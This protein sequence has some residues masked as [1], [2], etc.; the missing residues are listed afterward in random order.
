M[1]HQRLIY[2]ETA[3]EPYRNLAVEEYLTLH[4]QEGE[5]ILYLWQNRMTVVIGKNQNPYRE[6]RVTDLLKDGGHVVRRLSGGG[7][8]FHDLGNL[9]FTFMSRKEDYDLEEQ[10]GIIL[11]ACR[12]LGIEANFSGRNDLTVQGRKFSGN[13]FY[14]KGEYCY[15]HGTLLL[16]SD[17]TMIQK[18]LTV[19]TDKLTSKGVPSV[20]ARICN[21]CDFVPDLNVE[22]MREALEEAFAD[23]K[24]VRHLAFSDFPPHEIEKKRRF[25]ASD[26]WIF[27]RPISF[28]KE[29]TRRFSW[30]DLHLFLSAEKGRIA[31]VQVY[32][33]AMDQQIDAEL[34]QAL[35]G[36]PYENDA[37]VKAVHSLSK[38][39]TTLPYLSQAG[40]ED[41]IRDIA[42]MIEEEV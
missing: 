13:A 21:L 31:G 28:Q 23:G 17:P 39:R 16:H 34:K 30:G 4:V 9:N 26:S 41:M 19:D 36:I 20:S 38:Q 27:G 7:A 24:S 12:S 5:R 42:R 3:T 8:V 6:C 37:M 22:K 29:L 25:F 18:Y 14:T 10:L 11:R 35:V 32:S 2:H 33:D 15:H 1:I 40:K